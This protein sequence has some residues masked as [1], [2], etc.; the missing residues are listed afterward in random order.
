MANKDW[1][2]NGN[3]VWKTLG[4]SNH[5]VKERE[6]N[7]Y[8]ATDPIAIDKLLSAVRLPHIVW[9]CACGEGHLSKRLEEHGKYVF[10][11]D[12]VD[13]GYGFD[14]IDFLKTNTLIWDTERCA[15]VTNPPYKYAKEFVEHSLK[16]LKKGDLCCMF[17]KLTFLEGKAR[18][19]L[20][21]QSPPVGCSYFQNAFYAQKMGSFKKIKRVAVAQLHMLGLFGKKVTKGKQRWTGYE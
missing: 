10:S 5:S 17:L 1:K 7:D 20:F 12:L 14:G 18:R 2:G 15:I 4:A 11:S 16:L 6:E 3:S 13:Y 21:M 8:Y 9:E 19:K